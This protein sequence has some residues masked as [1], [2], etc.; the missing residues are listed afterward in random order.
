[1]VLTIRPELIRKSS[2]RPWS[3]NSHGDVFIHELRAH[4]GNWG[5]DAVTRKYVDLIEAG[6]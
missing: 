4:Q 1:M 2:V 3:C 6:S 5:Y